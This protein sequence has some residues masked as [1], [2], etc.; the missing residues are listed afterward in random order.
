VAVCAA[1]AI[2]LW[3][4]TP[5]LNG[6]FVFDDQYLPFF[7]PHYA[8]QN[9]IEAIRGVRPLLMFS[10]WI[11]NRMAGVEPFQYHLW[12]LAFHL[13]NSLLVFLIAR[14]IFELAAHAAPGRDWAAAAAA[15]IFLLHP[16]QTEAVSYV[17]SRSE[18]LSA[19][20]F[21]AAFAVFLCRRGT[22]VDWKTVAAITMLYAAAVSTKEHTITLAG[23]LLL[24][25]YYWNPGFT[26]AGIRR[27]WRL[28][29]PLAAAAV[30][31][32]FAAL[33][34]VRGA[35]SAGFGLKDLPWNHYLYTQFKALWVYFRL[36]LFPTG[37]NIDHAYPV[38]RSLLEP[39][40]LLGAAGLAA[41]MVAAWRWRK[42]FPVISFSFFGALLIFSPTSSILPIM[43]ALVER[44]LYLPMSLLVL[45]PADLL[46]RW[47]VR[48]A[49]RVA[50]VLIV[51][52]VL[53]VLCHQRNRVWASDVALWEDAVAKAPHNSR[54]HFQL[55]VAY[56][57][58]QRCAEA[59][60]HFE[61]AERLGTKDDTL[62]IDWALAADCLDQPE[63]AINLLK[64]AAGIRR[65]ALTF[66]QMALVH[67]KRK[68]YAEAMAALDEAERINPREDTIYF[69]R[70][71]V[72][73]A[74]GKPEEAAIQYRRAL[75]LNRDNEAA[76]RALAR[77]E[78]LKR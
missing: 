30:V 57:Q 15:A 21:L 52:V 53:A 19:L 62:Y 50:V 27:N 70:G 65:R 13:L 25:D 44:R 64:K 38:S 78:A 9:L 61:A 12:N 26:T 11:N 74:L 1:A 45:I 10:F 59:I 35:T 41:L 28:Y 77:L 46:L 58:Q 6:V 54:A 23:L 31:L 34:L 3:A 18:N 29:A 71:N 5:A 4:Y 60:P 17:A 68:Q 7:S 72:L 47:R 51:V 42:R 73:V 32:A 24:T 76:R 39:A 66:T 36:F 33:R 2:A 56:Y 75:E 8:E 40:V 14:R 37:Q 49:L 48:A 63:L 43:D 16:V 22:A 20:F 69:Y 55:A 67:G